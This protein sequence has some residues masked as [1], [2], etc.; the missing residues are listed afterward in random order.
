MTSLKVSPAVGLNENGELVAIAGTGTSN[1]RSYLFNSELPVDSNGRLVIAGLSSSAIQQLGVFDVT[2]YGA[3]GGSTDDTAAVNAALAA[4]YANKG[5]K[6]Y[7]P[8]MMA[9]YSFG[10]SIVIDPTA[11]Y[12]GSGI[13]VELGGNSFNP[14]HTGWCFDIKTNFFHANCGGKLG[15]KPVIIQGDGANVYNGGGATALGGVRF[16]DS[17]TYALRDI[18]I[19]DYTGGTACQLNITSNDLSTWV[20][21]GQIADLR[22]SNN[23]VG[24]WTKSTNIIGSFLGNFFERI[25]FEGRVNNCKNFWFQGL[26]FNCQINM[27]GG[28]YNQMGT[29]GGCGFYLDGG[30][31]GTTFITP[32]I[33]AGGAGTQSALTDFVFGPNYTSNLSYFPVMINTIEINLPLNWRDKMLVATPIGYGTLDG[34]VAASPREV[35]RSARTYYVNGTTGSDTANTGMKDYNNVIHPF[36]T[37]QKAL[38]VIYGTL[39]CA[40]KNVTIQVQDG[41][42]TETITISG[43]PT[44]LGAATLSIVGNST[45][46]GNVKFSTVGDALTV[47]NGARV[48]I[49]GLT[50]ASSSGNAINTYGQGSFVYVD[51]GCQFGTCNLAHMKVG[52]GAEIDTGA[53]YKITGNARTHWEIAGGTVVKG[54]PIDATNITFSANFTNV[55]NRANLFI[56]DTSFT[57]TGSTGT[58]FYVYAGGLVQS[59]GAANTIMPGNAA[60]YT[61]TGT[62]GLYL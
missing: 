53:S 3:K 32:W 15:N 59:Y 1:V 22:G 48:T 7:F 14:T 25:A 8:F 36:Q 55:Y 61:D 12:M 21:H 13:L 31:T 54:A 43:Q 52:T 6:L 26:M 2:A 42:W 40:G 11:Y 4:L 33:D 29:T 18:V 35:L 30:Y 45:T 57:I 49:N 5:G 50:L 27:C 56:N 10:S 46:P 44:G 19:N 17:V 20:E 9:G 16:N 60:G 28:Y 58:K 41:T 51:A 23:L 38:D 34:G 37:V 39:D 24:L 47:K 62:G